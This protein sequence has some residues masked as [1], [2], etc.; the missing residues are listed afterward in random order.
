MDNEYITPTPER[1]AKAAHWIVPPE[2]QEINGRKL[3]KATRSGYQHASVVKIMHDCGELRDEQLQAF[4][5]LEKDHMLAE[6]TPYMR[7]KGGP[8]IDN[9]EPRECPV[10]RNVAARTRY[11]AATSSLGMRHSMV[12]GHCM[13]E[14]ASKFSVGNMLAVGQSISKPTAI[15]NGK[16]AI[17]D[18]TFALAVHYDLFR[19]PPTR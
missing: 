18:A 16:A 9:G 2:S 7:P 17:R 14:Y 10:A 6:L 8:T 1:L 3:T 5:R 13:M 19:H 4:A 15:K 12:L 11:R